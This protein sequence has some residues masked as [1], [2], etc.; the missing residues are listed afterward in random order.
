MFAILLHEGMTPFYQNIFSFPTAVFTIFLGVCTLFW[1][2]AVLGFIDID[3]FDV[4]SNLETGEISGIGGILFKFGLNGV[5]LTIVISLLAFFGWICSYITVALIN[6]IVPTR[7]LEI[8]VGVPIFVAVSY[9]SVLI[10]SVALRPL[11]RF[12]K[13]LETTSVKHIIGGVALVRS[14][15]VNASFGEAR[16]EDGGAG[17]LLRVRSRGDMEYKQ[18]DRVVLLEYDALSG[19]YYVVTEEEFNTGNK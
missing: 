19:I 5:P 3:F 16:F 18:G 9:V 2:V 8:L 17:M 11:R 15:V 7:L 13:K 10:T 14:S 12:F 4:D 6:P 1:L